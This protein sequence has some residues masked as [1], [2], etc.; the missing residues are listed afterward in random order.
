VRDYIYKDSSRLCRH[1]SLL[2]NQSGRWGQP[3]AAQAFRLSGHAH[4]CLAGDDP[5][6]KV[7]V[8]GLPDPHRT[9]QE[10]PITVYQLNRNWGAIPKLKFELSAGLQRGLNPFAHELQAV[11]CAA[12]EIFA[13]AP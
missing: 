10:E 7:R 9:P 11:C 8:E 4:S 12:F 2:S 6:L 3:R 13:F 5:N 1:E